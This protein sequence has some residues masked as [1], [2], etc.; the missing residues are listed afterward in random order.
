MVSPVVPVICAGP[1]IASNKPVL[2]NRRKWTEG[3]QCIGNPSGS[4]S[5]IHFGASQITP[6]ILG[7]FA[8]VFAAPD[9]PVGIIRN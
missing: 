4:L 8:I 6:V 5:P 3:S 1:T 9:F 7:I 2:L